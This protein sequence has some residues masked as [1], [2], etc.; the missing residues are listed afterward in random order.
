[1]QLNDKMNKLKSITLWIAVLTMALSS[2]SCS[3]DEEPTMT[4]NYDASCNESVKIN[5]SDIDVY[6]DLKY[7]VSGMV[8][9]DNQTDLENMDSLGYVILNNYYK[10][11][12][13]I[14]EVIGNVLVCWA[15]GW[16]WY[17][18]P[19]HS[20]VNTKYSHAERNTTYYYRLFSF[21]YG[22][23]GGELVNIWLHY[24][25]IAEFT[26]PK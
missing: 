24:G 20:T 6:F 13:A 17:F 4:V 9:S 18:D 23:E 1:M 11:D 10:R 25:D 8:I 3:K 26:T 7:N 21:G 15:A 5:I 14:D 16:N 2:V 19:E 12:G 22:R